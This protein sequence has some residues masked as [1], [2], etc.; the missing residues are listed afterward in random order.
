VEEEEVIQPR[1]E[2]IRAQVGG[3]S[4]SSTFPAIWSEEGKYLATVLGDALVKGL[5]QVSQDRP[6]DPVEYLANFLK[7]Y[8]GG[9]ILASN[10]PEEVQ[11]RLKSG[12][13]LSPALIERLRTGQIL[14]ASIKE[15]EDAVTS[16]P[17]EDFDPVTEEKRLDT[18]AKKLITKL[19]SDNEDEKTE[20]NPEH[21]GSLEEMEDPEDN[22]NED[23]SGSGGHGGTRDDRGQ[24][25]LHFA[26]AR[27]GGASTILAF[28]QNPSV[29][30]SWRDENGRTAR[31]VAVGL[32]RA[33]NVR[34][35]DG[36][37]VSLAVAGDKDSL[38]HLLID[39]YSEFSVEEN[40]THVIDLAEKAGKRDVALFL[41]AIPD[42]KD[43]LEKLHKAVR[44]G[45]LE[46]VKQLTLKDHRL[47]SAL[48]EKGRTAL[49]IGVL[50]E[51]F[52][53]VK[54]LCEQFSRSVLRRG[55]SVRFNKYINNGGFRVTY[56][57]CF[58]TISL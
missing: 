21:I 35:I 18:E 22:N 15:E 27:P 57:G 13:A 54:W 7:S 6:D 17:E 19:D 29:N 3:S 38:Q 39:G 36:W 52:A 45:D 55:D 49:H 32:G 20:N 2:V 34:T 5:T 46:G 9:E 47:A 28:L 1:E 50:C 33:E 12:R 37:I 10:I 14:E 31:D 8:K 16:T 11:A 42:F 26:A 58:V 48:N 23:S 51:Q 4:S 41:R 44:S 53:I 25:V 56:K 40:K 43:R 30:L 24:S